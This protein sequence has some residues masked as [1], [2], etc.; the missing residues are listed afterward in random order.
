[1]LKLIPPGRRK[2][3]TYYI[4]R[5]RVGGKLVE[6]SCRTADKAS[7]ERYAIAALAEL[8]ASAAD[9]QSGEPDIERPKTFRDAAVA[10]TG[11]RY[12]PLSDQERAAL[13]NGEP[14]AREKL[15]Q[16]DRAI[17]EINHLVAE[18]GDRRLADIKHADLV[19]ASIK[20]YPNHK[21][22]SRNRL[23]ITPASAILH[24]AADQGWCAYQRLARFKEPRAVTRAVDMDSAQALIAAA[25]DM[26][27][28][29]MTA[30]LTFLFGQGMRISDAIAIQWPRLDLTRGTIE[31]DIEKSD[32]TVVKALQEDVRAALA[33]MPAAPDSLGKTVGYVFPWRNRWAFYRALAP[34]LKATGIRFTPHMA[35]H[36]LGKWL[37]ASGAGLRSI[38]D[39][40]DHKDP[41]SSMRYQSTDVKGQRL[42]LGNV[43]KFVGK[44]EKAS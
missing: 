33:A 21:A 23:G 35:R 10:Y 32:E 36:S 11:F 16:V 39:I 15:K 2:G 19:A 42:A 28:P 6:F 7:A 38:M 37:N 3:N 44:T 40:L 12:P 17:K 31:V 26:G 5:G 8:T 1:M 9:A 22:S 24:Y 13:R 29:E 25:Q 20:L 4:A 41:K 27:E 34:V 14:A 18:L 30:A 43:G